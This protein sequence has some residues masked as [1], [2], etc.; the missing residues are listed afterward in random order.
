MENIL[1]VVAV[2]MW[3]LLL[4]VF[5]KYHVRLNFKKSS[6]TELAKYYMTKFKVSDAIAKK[7]T[8][9]D[10]F[11]KAFSFKDFDRLN[12][13]ATSLDLAQDESKAVEDVTAGKLW[14]TN[15]TKLS[16]RLQ[17]T[18]FL[19]SFVDILKSYAKII[20][21]TF[22]LQV[23][24]GAFI[25]YAGVTIFATKAV[26]L[27]VLSL[28]L[29]LI[30]MIADIAILG[31]TQKRNKKLLDKAEQMGKPLYLSNYLLIPEIQQYIVSYLTTEKNI[32]KL[33]ASQHTDQV[34]KLMQKLTYGYALIYLMIILDN[35]RMANAVTKEISAMPNSLTLNAHLDMDIRRA[36]IT[37]SQSLQD[38]NY[39]KSLAE[40]SKTDANAFK[41]LLDN[42][43]QI[44]QFLFTELKNV[45]SDYLELQDQ[46]LNDMP[47]KDKQAEILQYYKNFDRAGKAL[48][49]GNVNS[50]ID[51]TK[52]PQKKQ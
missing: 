42:I 23:I 5:L 49:T 35:V 32:S 37:V 34:T 45:L 31:V 29:A 9:A 17:L 51:F 24:S 12:G 47:S 18:Q 1:F 15:D 10:L 30:C 4:C 22:I 19:V 40:L 44:N 3:L 14:F 20:D 52:K 21:D 50:I 13:L 39:L 2:I 27:P 28:I 16:F 33:A 41:D 38:D 48:T 26:I 6:V 11:L 43:N 46:I 7:I 25:L 8:F 36:I